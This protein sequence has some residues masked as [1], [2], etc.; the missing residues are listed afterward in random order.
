MW[1][2]GLAG[3]LLGMPSTG[4]GQTVE[5]LNKSVEAATTIVVGRLDQY[6][7]E[8]EMMDR[9]VQED[10][11]SS[12]LITGNPSA[13]VMR[14]VQPRGTYVFTVTGT[15]IGHPPQPL[16]VRLPR[17]MDAE[18]AGLF[19]EHT[20]HIPLK[21]RYLLMMS[22]DEVKGF[23]P[24]SQAPI[25]IDAKARVPKEPLK[26]AKPEAVLS[27][28]VQVLT[29]SLE[30]PAAR[31][32]A[33]ELL[34]GAKSDEALQAM[35]LLMNDADAGVRISA[36]ECMAENQDVTAIPIIGK[37]NLADGALEKYKTAAAIPYLNALV[38]DAPSQWTRLNAAMALRQMPAR[39]K[40]SIPFLIKALRDPEN[41]NT[42]SDAYYCLR[43][44]IPGLPVPNRNGTRGSA[45]Y[46]DT[47]GA[48][49]VWWADEEAGKHK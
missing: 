47:A 30:D 29:D 46:E 5:A 9:M 39:D 26:D 11:R 31:V 17:V 28:V 24:T 35:R 19:S 3:G 34:A 16:V 7:A 6:I 4:R 36:L 12:P 43:D 21:G 14:T 49:Q 25:A 10:L 33:A 8:P 48:A 37:G 13:I 2:L 42:S 44:L 38:A 23:S 18:M 15:I 27:A 1:L 45:R 40:S 22:G 20:L 32:R 41:P